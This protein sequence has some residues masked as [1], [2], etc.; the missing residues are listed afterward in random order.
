LGCRLLPI[1][2]EPTHCRIPETVSAML[3]ISFSKT[4]QEFLTCLLSLSVVAMHVLSPSISCFLMMTPSYLVS[5]LLILW[6]PQPFCSCVTFPLP[7]TMRHCFLAVVNTCVVRT[8][9]VVH[10]IYSRR[11]PCGHISSM[12]IVSI[13]IGLIVHL[14]GDTSR[15][16]KAFT[17]KRMI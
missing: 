5:S 3:L 12:L 8:D 16:G 1:I 14:K 2:V 7:R 17:K 13:T 6:L 10:N 15:G 11:W 4:T 9:P